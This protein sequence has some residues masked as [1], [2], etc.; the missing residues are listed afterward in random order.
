MHSALLAVWI[1]ESHFSCTP[2]LAQ[3]TGAYV[4]SALFNL[5]ASQ[6]DHFPTALKACGE[7]CDYLAGGALACNDGKGKF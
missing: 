5:R 6:S 2:I 7:S 4:V 3:S 1:G